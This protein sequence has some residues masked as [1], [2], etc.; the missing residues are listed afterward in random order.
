MDIFKVKCEKSKIPITQ[1]TLQ[2]IKFNIK[3]VIYSFPL[4]LDHLY[5]YH[6]SWTKWIVL[7][8]SLLCSFLVFLAAAFLLSGLD[9]I[10][11][12]ASSRDLRWLFLKLRDSRSYLDQALEGSDL[13]WLRLSLFEFVYKCN[14]HVLTLIRM[15]LR[16]GGLWIS[17]RKSQVSALNFDCKRV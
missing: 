2:G 1:E 7:I 11:C 16:G 5:Y 10:F 12:V 13:A 9:N 3:I 17:F 14:S 4:A 8:S 6:L 15:G